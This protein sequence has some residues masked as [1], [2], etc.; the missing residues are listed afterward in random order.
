MDQD[1]DVYRDLSEEAPQVWEW[2]GCWMLIVR[3]HT[4]TR[5]IFVRV[6]SCKNN[7]VCTPGRDGIGLRTVTCFRSWLFCSVSKEH[8]DAYN[9]CWHHLIGSSSFD[10]VTRGVSL[11]SV[12]SFLKR[13]SFDARFG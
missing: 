4:C 7:G 3:C 8:S 11:V 6:F 13:F 5:V 9:K 12:R 10:R 1:R 2:V